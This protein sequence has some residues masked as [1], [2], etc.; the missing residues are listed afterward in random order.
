MILACD[1][2]AFPL[3]SVIQ[4][5]NATVVIDEITTF[6]IIYLCKELCGVDLWT[7]MDPQLLFYYS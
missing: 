7:H 5:K 1:V 3:R 6:V 2:I 4:T